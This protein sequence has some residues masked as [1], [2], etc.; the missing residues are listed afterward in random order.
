MWQRE[1]N[2][3]QYC[4]LTK[5]LFKFNHLCFL[6][7]PHKI[8]Y[9]WDKKCLQGE[10]CRFLLTWWEVTASSASQLQ[11]KQYQIPHSQKNHECLPLFY[12]F[13]CVTAYLGKSSNFGLHFLQPN[14]NILTIILPQ[15][16]RPKLLLLVELERDWRIWLDCSKCFDDAWELW[17]AQFLHFFWG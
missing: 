9:G 4:Q 16:P 7:S 13:V 10:V 15:K 3:W 8:N 6:Y 17:E 1:Q 2:N 12:P 14:L 11:L 5:C